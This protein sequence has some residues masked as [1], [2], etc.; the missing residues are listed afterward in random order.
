[1]KF[2]KY[3]PLKQTCRE[4]TQIIKKL[5]TEYKADVLGFG[6]K[7]YK[8]YPNKWKKLEKDWNDKYFKDIKVNINVDL[9]I[10]TTGSLTETL[11]EANK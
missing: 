4:N 11:K 5:Q 8:K 7:I 2:Q 10:A 1:M 3:S 9:K 6:N